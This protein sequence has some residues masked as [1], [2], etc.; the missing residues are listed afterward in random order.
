MAKILK[1][2]NT[3]ATKQVGQGPYCSGSMTKES[4][5][6]YEEYEGRRLR[7]LPTL[8]TKAFEREGLCSPDLKVS[9]NFHLTWQI[10]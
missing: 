6:E 10:S 7:L 2:L 5:R 1:N 4:T 3:Q 8:C 9:P